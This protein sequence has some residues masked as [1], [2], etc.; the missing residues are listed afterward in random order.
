[1]A[2][3]CTYS[4]KEIHQISIGSYCWESVSHV[5]NLEQVLDFSSPTSAES[6]LQSVDA[7]DFHLFVSPRCVKDAVYPP[8]PGTIGEAIFRPVLASWH[9]AGSS[10]ILLV[11]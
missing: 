10:G 3:S 5:R 8:M 2:F 4:D 1:M 9:T 11:W 7:T 6:V